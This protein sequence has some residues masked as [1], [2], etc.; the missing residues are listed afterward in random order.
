ML[1]IEK[2]TAGLLEYY[3]CVCVHSLL[4]VFF[5]HYYHC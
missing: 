1:C 2:G 4:C 3:V 5:M